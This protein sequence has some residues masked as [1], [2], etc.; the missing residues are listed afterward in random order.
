MEASSI[1]WLINAL[2]F[3]YLETGLL[4]IIDLGAAADL[5][6]GINYVPKEFLL[7]PR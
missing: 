7:D 2:G 5:R 4:K 3:L 1:V 6:V